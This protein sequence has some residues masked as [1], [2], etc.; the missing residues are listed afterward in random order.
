MLMACSVVKSRVAQNTRQRP[1]PDAAKPAPWWADR[2]TA[3]VARGHG[4]RV[5]HAIRL[6]AKSEAYAD[7][8]GPKL[9]N[10]WTNLSRESERLPTP[11]RQG[12]CPW[13]HGDGARVV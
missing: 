3:L 2:P 1:A 13:G 7:G 11:W 4:G 8:Y 6:V 5:G 10:I 9:I 12:A